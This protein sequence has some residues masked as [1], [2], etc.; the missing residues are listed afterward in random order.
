MTP[1]PFDHPTL[2]DD[3][4]RYP[5]TLQLLRVTAATVP[6][7]SGGESTGPGVGTVPPTVLY[8]SAVQQLRTDTLAPRDREP[9]LA[10]DPNGIGLSAGYYL[11]R[12]A[13]SYGGLPVYE[14]PGVS[15]SGSGTAGPAG[16]AGPAGAT[17]PAGPAGSS[18]LLP[19]LTADQLATLSASLTP[20]QLGNLNNLNACQLQVL[21]QLP[22]V[23]IQM[24]TT[25]MNQ[26]EVGNVVDG[27]NFTQ[28]KSVT[29]TTP[30]TQVVVASSAYPQLYQALNQFLTP[31]QVS[32]VLGNLN[33]Q[34][35][36]TLN[37]LTPVQLQGL[38]Q[39]SVAQLQKLGNMTMPQI[40]TLLNAGLN[41]FVQGSGLRSTQ[42][43]V[44]SL[45]ENLNAPQLNK[46]TNNLT[47]QQLQNFGQA[48]NAADIGTALDGLTP[49]QLGNLANYTPSTI[50]S[51]FTMTIANLA[52]FLGL[53]G[54]PPSPHLGNQDF[55][56]A[57]P[58]IVGQPSAT[59]SPLQSGY[60]PIVVDSNTGRVW[61]YAGGAWAQLGFNQ[62]GGTLPLSQLPPVQTVSFGTAIASIPNV[63]TLYKVTVTYNQLATASTNTTK[64]LVTVP[65][66]TAY[67]LG[68]LKHSTS[69]TGGGLVGYTLGLLESAAGTP[70]MS[71]FSVFQA[72]GATTYATAVHTSGITHNLSHT[73]TT[74]ITLTI[75]STGANINAATQGTCDIWL[76]LLAML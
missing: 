36:G 61:A 11:A 26:T 4:P 21:M 2:R 43:T 30:R 19:G 75:Q 20:A 60:A 10:T 54:P 35:L 6:G 70:L 67:L 68:K 44:Q 65:A 17:G 15:P 76:L 47:S 38:A 3:L 73:A 13:G 69:F 64:T 8:V 66:G 46:L 51:L 1:S 23:N 62:F 53:S 34:Q 71:A 37:G 58:A 74:N 28:L 48:L 50:V 63:P 33:S 31:A 55:F 52:T 57:L 29:T 39:L 41:F 40:A 24:L 12:L 14:V 5:Q 18:G 42:S 9:C 49:N 59:P 16:P 56:P 7:P 22:V 72:V 27:L 32:Y 25:D 45:L